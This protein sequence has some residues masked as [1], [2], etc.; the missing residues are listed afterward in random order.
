MRGLDMVGG[1]RAFIPPKGTFLHI[2]VYIYREK[3][4]ERERKREKV[5]ETDS[6]WH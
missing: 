6:D 4:R 5:M 3:E 1:D 2:Y